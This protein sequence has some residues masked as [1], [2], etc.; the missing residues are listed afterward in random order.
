MNC[1]SS[2]CDVVAMGEWGDLPCEER[3]LNSDGVGSG[4]AMV[5]GGG[6]LQG[7]LGFNDGF[8][9]SRPVLNWGDEPNLA[10]V[11]GCISRVVDM[12]KVFAMTSCFEWICRGIMGLRVLK[13]SSIGIFFSEKWVFRGEV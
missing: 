11:K 7:I 2:I 1:R 6:V 10:T 9:N 5:C 3:E 12:G 8:V 4:G 13:L